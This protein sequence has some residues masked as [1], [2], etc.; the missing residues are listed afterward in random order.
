[1]PT[2]YIAKDAK[3]QNSL[4]AEESNVYGTIDF[5]MLLSDVTIEQGAVVRN[6]IIMPTRIEEGALCSTRFVAEDCVIGKNTV[7][8]RRP[9]DMKNEDDCGFNVIGGGYVIP[10]NSDCG[11]KG[12]NQGG[13]FA[14]WFSILSGLHRQRRVV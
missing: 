3:V 9:E 14:P 12:A 10:P 11:Q 13:A 4:V 6:S 2:N 1:M 5:A 7:V 8:V